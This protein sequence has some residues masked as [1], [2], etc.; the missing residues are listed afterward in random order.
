MRGADDD[1]GDG[2]RDANLDARVAFLGQLALEE[3]VELGV[4]DAVGDELSTL[5]TAE[6]GPCQQ[7]YSAGSDVSS[8]FLGGAPP[9]LRSR[10]AVH[11][12]GQLTLG[13]P[14]SPF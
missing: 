14:E 9:R 10:A 4:E 6:G 11:A 13:R 5:G 8:V 2:R 7:I 12:G 3:F 1:V